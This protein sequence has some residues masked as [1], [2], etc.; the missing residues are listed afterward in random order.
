MPCIRLL[1]YFLTLLVYV[2]VW[3]KIGVMTHRD[4]FEFVNE[5]CSTMNREFACAIWRRLATPAP[6]ES[7]TR[8]AHCALRKRLR[9]CMARAILAYTGKHYNVAYTL[10]LLDAFT[11]MK[12][13]CTCTWHCIGWYN[14]PVPSFIHVGCLG[15]SN[16]YVCCPVWVLQQICWISLGKWHVWSLLAHVRGIV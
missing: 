4:K 6:R 9:P 5:L 15:I 2:S 8:N 1:V 12:P 14:P 16:K 7:I 3:S 10:F 13:G 11:C